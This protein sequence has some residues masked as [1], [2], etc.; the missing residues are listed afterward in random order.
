MRTKLI[1]RKELN[2]EIIATLLTGQKIDNFRELLA[3]LNS[4]K[5][6]AAGLDQD[7]IRR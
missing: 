5:Y 6:L 7:R 2:E 1:D 3:S 4:R